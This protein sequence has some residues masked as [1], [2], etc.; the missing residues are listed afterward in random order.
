M[1]SSHHHCPGHR[2]PHHHRCHRHQ[3]TPSIRV[4]RGSTTGSLNT[5]GMSVNGGPSFTI[6]GAG[7]VSTPHNTMD[8]GSGNMVVAGSIQYGTTISKKS[9]RALKTNIAHEEDATFAALLK[10]EPVTYALKSDPQATRTHGFIA[11][12]VQQHFPELI[13]HVMIADPPRLALQY[14]Q[15]ISMLVHGVQIL[16]QRIEKL[17]VMVQQQQSRI[18]TFEQ[19]N[20]A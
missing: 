20:Q 10:L 13:T 5:A 6:N 9:D 11:Q 19:W 14:D 3:D 4:I 12:Q 18:A 8:D 2:H 7:V 15:V 1:N 16:N 17:E